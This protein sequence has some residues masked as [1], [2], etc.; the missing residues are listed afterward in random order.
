[1]LK[2]GSKSYSILKNK[3]PK[4]HQGNFFENKN[5]YQLKTVLTMKEYCTHCGFKFQIEPS[6]FYGAMY[7]SY[8]ITVALSILTFVVLY[9]LG[10]DLL[11]RFI[12]II[13]SLILF[14]PLTLRLARLIYS[15]IFI[16]YDSSYKNEDGLKALDLGSTKSV[17]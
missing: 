4:C 10:F 6:F 12:G 14:T 16:S 9:L 2:K 17:D 15:N 8:A 5:P 1:M 13:I 7:V 3:C 11:S